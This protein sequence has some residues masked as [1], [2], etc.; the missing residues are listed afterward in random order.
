MK[1]FDT[2]MHGRKNI[3]LQEFMLVHLSKCCTSRTTERSLNKSGTDSNSPWQPINS[4]LFWINI[5][6]A[7]I[8]L[9]LND[10]SY[11]KKWVIVQKICT[12]M[13]CILHTNLQLVFQTYSDVNIWGGGKQQKTLWPHTIEFTVSICAKL[14]KINVKIESCRVLA[15][16]NAIFW[17]TQDG[18]SRFLLNVVTLKPV[19]GIMSQMTNQNTAMKLDHTWRTQYTLC[20]KSLTIP[21][22]TSSSGSAGLS[23]SSASSQS[24][25]FVVRQL[26]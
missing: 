3:K 2:M 26:H 1:Q 15:K 21:P 4:G 11:L 5:T 13:K 25:H 22:Q 7:T 19:H 20:D 17:N 14:M 18:C 10:T 9:K 23:I 24:L 8:K 12:D 6:T 16:K